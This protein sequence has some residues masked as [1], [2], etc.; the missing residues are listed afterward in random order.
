MKKR[1]LAIILFFFLVLVPTGLI[2]LMNS[3]AGSRWLINTTFAFLPGKVSV[4]KTEGTLLSHLSLQGVDYQ[5]DTEAVTVKQLDVTWQPSQLFSN[6]LKIVDLSVN[7]LDMNFI[8]TEQPINKDGNGFDE[9]FKLPIKL[10]IDNLLLHNARFKYGDMVYELDTLQLAVASEADQLK[11]LSLTVNSKLIVAT[12][13]GEVTLV[14]GLPLNLKLDWQVN[15]GQNGLWQGKTNIN[16]N[17][18]KLLVDNRLTSPFTSVLTG[19]VENATKTPNLDFKADWQNLVWP[20][21][22][23]LKQIQNSQGHL[24]LTGPLTHYQLNLNGKLS[25]PYLP[26]ADL[27]I[28]SNGSLDGITLKQLEL[29]SGIGAL[30]VAGQIF[31]N[32]KPAFDLTAT[33]KNFNPGILIPELPGNLTFNTHIKGQIEP[34]KTQVAA[35]LNQI[36][37]QLRKQPF[38]ADGKLSLNGEQLKVNQ[39][40]IASGKNNLIVDGNLTKGQ[41]NLNLDIDM[42]LLSALWPDLAGNFTGNGEL[43]GGWSNPTVNLAL[44][45]Q[46]LRFRQYRTENLKLKVDYSPDT[47]KNS[48]VNLSASDINIGSTKISKVSIDGVGSLKQ[49]EF[50]AYI[51]SPQGDL[52]M[53]LLG[54]L[55]GNTWQGKISN[56]DF[57]EIGNYLWTLDRNLVVNIINKQDGIDV[58][59]DTSCLIQKAAAL[60]SQG[61]YS[62][63]GDLDFHL[64]TKALPSRL[65]NQ[66]LPERIDTDFL[67]NGELDV[68]RKNKILNGQY[69]FKTT[70]TQIL[71]T[72]NEGKRELNLDA[73][74]AS[75]TIKGDQISANVNLNINAHDYVR[76]QFLADIGK[77]Q[78]ISGQI[79]AAITDFSIIRLFAPQLSNVRGN[80]TADV[81]LEGDLSKPI[82]KGKID[83]VDGNLDAKQFGLRQVNLHALASGIRG[84]QIHIQGS[85]IPVVLNKTDSTESIELKTSVNYTADFQQANKLAGN[86]RL[87]LAPNTAIT[88]TSQGQTH[89]INLNH[90][91][92]FGTL[93]QDLLTSE[94]SINL[95]GQDYLHG[96][97][98]FNM[99]SSQNL[100]GQADAAIHNFEFVEAIA[101][102]LSNVKGLLT[103]N[104]AIRG[105]TQNPLIT[106]NLTLNKGEADVNLLG[107]EVREINLLATSA[108]LN[109]DAIQLRGSAKSG[110]GNIKLDGAINLHSNEHWP[111]RLNLTGTNFE[112]AKLPEAEIAISPDLLF[113]STDQFKKITGELA[114]PKAILKL[115]EYPENAVKVSEDEIILGEEK[116]ENKNVPEPDIQADIEV[117]LGKEVSFSGQGLRTDLSGDLK[118]VKTNTKMAMQGTVEMKKANYKRFGQNLTVRKGRFI[119]NGPADNPWLDVE[120]IR[121]SKNKKVTAILNLSGALKNPQTRISSEPSLPESE[122]LA[123]LVTGNPFNQVS[124]ADSNVLA[125]AALSYGAGQAIWLADKLGVDEFNVEEGS[126]LKDTL[127]T[128][129]QYLTPD[130]YIGAKVGMFNKQAALVLKRKISENINV[131][132]QT[133]TSQRVKLNYEF[134]E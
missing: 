26:H 80:L 79:K 94:L 12:A 7:G 29:N 45:G 20:F 118:I 64:D 99:E 110:K 50:D 9:N 117:K 108:T 69:H 111:I 19:S 81:G 100:S 84:N 60:C 55:K 123:Y 51:L 89:Q 38:H 82:V 24:I 13:K 27:L 112:M 83:L 73:S 41:G 115:Q 44:K 75:G 3:E 46:G 22:G 14:K 30:Q 134:D 23:K 92:L 96:K 103:A 119:F 61:I 49:H 127:L 78:T 31:W 102:E 67:I 15:T 17:L 36:R 2:G 42:P 21:T 53:A 63:N 129:G 121:L 1:S 59:L 124:K 32:T 28:E 87:T 33:G 101:P 4:K 120:A 35:E 18:H 133:G 40:V 65:M 37:G 85:A 62:A 57:K 8:K 91:S 104:M 125:S 98:M 107:I 58:S 25:Q 122:A 131:E 90:A 109:S 114:V 95:A 6:T 77:A 54:N 74:D 71:L 34:D 132:S 47:R 93:D 10:D 113:H 56:L 76:S 43:K 66:F 16:G 126:T 5:T 70:P 52:S 116:S 130:F 106:G 128:M 39:L 68:H 105:T 86:F 97:L 48:Q 11:L 72:T 88:M